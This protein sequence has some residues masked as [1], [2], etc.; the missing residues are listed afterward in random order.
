[1]SPW[2]RPN[3]AYPAVAGTVYST[4]P[5]PEAMT[6]LDTAPAFQPEP[7]GRR[8]AVPTTSVRRSRSHVIGSPARS[9]SAVTVF[10]PSI[11]TSQVRPVPT[12]PP[13]QPTST[14]PG[15]GVAASSTSVSPA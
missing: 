11:V 3:I 12:H 15:S 6:L 7:V 13:D 5:S 9:N 14:E 10:G 1:M 2:L 8:N 4:Y